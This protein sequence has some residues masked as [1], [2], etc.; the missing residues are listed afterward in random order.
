[1]TTVDAPQIFKAGALDDSGECPQVTNTAYTVYFVPLASPSANN[2]SAPPEPIMGIQQ[3]K[4][5]FTLNQLTPKAPVP[6]NKAEENVGESELTVKWTNASDAKAKSQYYVLWDLGIGPD[7]TCSE[8]IL[9]HD[10]P[11]PDP[12]DDEYLLKSDETP[13]QEMTLNHLDERGVA[14]GDYVAAA[15]IHKDVAGNL[16]NMSRILCLKRDMTNGFRDICAMDSEC[17][18]TTCALTP[19]QRRSGALLG[20]L[21]TLG[22]LLFLRR[23]RA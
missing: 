14:I 22:S 4:A 1:V 17:H 11:P 2:P 3:L 18:F 20:I 19:G 15:V 21:I 12:A 7:P 23:R 9:V 6:T 8:S 16:S 10:Q 5:T 13:G